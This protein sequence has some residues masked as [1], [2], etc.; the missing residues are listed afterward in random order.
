M[1]APLFVGRQS[2]LSR[3]GDLVARSGTT[4]RPTVAIVRGEMGVGKTQLLDQVQ[5]QL[6]AVTTLT[7]VGYEL[8]RHVPLAAGQDLLRSLSAV[9]HEGPRLAALLTGPRHQLEHPVQVFEAAR[10]C[11]TTVGPTVLVIDDLQWVDELTCA[12]AH[13]LLRAARDLGIPLS[14]LVA[15]RPA[16]AAGPFIDSVAR[17]IADPGQLLETSLEPLGRADGVHLVM[18]LCPDL[19]EAGGGNGLGP[20]RRNPVLAW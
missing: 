14:A 4:S 10:R 19:D 5:R 11:L 13:Y 1:S 2:E 8:E 18:R 9:E 6:G 16:E 3:I 7:I 12:L 15:T 17:L 20:C